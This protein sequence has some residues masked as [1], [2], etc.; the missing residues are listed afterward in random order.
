MYNIEKHR[1]ALLWS[2][3]VAR[4]D[5]DGSGSLSQA[6]KQQ[7]LDTLGGQIVG[8]K[9]GI[10]TPLRA[11]AA[12]TEENEVVAALM[13]QTGVQPPLAT[14]Y[15][16]SSNDGY[17]FIGR[18][19]SYP[20]FDGRYPVICTMRKEVCFG[21]DFLNEN[22]TTSDAQGL[23]KN[24]AFRHP[25]CG[26]CMIIA[27]LAASGET[28]FSAFLP[29]RSA[30]QSVKPASKLPLHI[31][32][33]SKDWQAADFSL[34]EHAQTDH[35]ARRLLA[36]RLIQR[37]S[38]VLGE[39][40]IFFDAMKGDPERTREMLRDA[41]DRRPAFLAIDDA[42]PANITAAEARLHAKC[43]HQ[44]HSA[45]WPQAASHERTFARIRG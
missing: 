33:H 2:F 27:L 32:N 18:N 4:S 7:M 42:L 34:P 24:V 36:V 19:S 16:F 13:L 41:T 39:S 17:P 43:L 37:Y 14:R 45:S 21:S 38:Y 12:D 15:R 26:D 29:T 8:D 40:D 9:I 20:V 1:E 35:Q 6:E 30:S 44:W 3:I 22:A 5:H 28:G 23:F 11:A 10:R 25:K 31:G